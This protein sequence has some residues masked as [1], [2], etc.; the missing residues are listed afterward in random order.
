MPE[1]PEVET[2]RRG[3]V[4]HLL[5]R[6][7]RK[8]D[9]S[10]PKSFIG[11]PDTVLNSEITS[12]ERRGKM[13]IIAL[14]NNLFI[15][16]HLRMTGQL[17][18]VGTDSRFGG[19]HP[20][21]SLVGQL[22]DKHTRVTITLD[23]GTHLYFNDQRKFGFIQVLD[24]D[25]IRQLPFLR[26]L[27]PEPLDDALT[28]DQFIDRFARKGKSNVKAALLDQSTIAGIGNIYADESL[29]L[30]QIHPETHVSALARPD[31]DR[32]L[33]AIRTCLTASLNSGGSTI[34]NYR[35]ADGTKGDYLNKFAQVFHRDGQP[36]NV[37][38]TIIIKTRVAGRGTHL[39]PTCQ[40][41]K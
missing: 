31:F 23:D 40:K 24:Q 41:L 32:L 30:S 11:V 21:D 27:G 34:E 13:L 37:C 2:I 25:G 16:I 33:T 35:K 9:I 15:T 36:C 22:P 7:I 6:S 1:L 14:A 18:Y 20:T 39:C 3:L 29:F 28:L 19:G 10:S 12:I 17:I 38:G 4:P 5:H 26:A 8:I